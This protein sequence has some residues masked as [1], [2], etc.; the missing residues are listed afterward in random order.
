MLICYLNWYLQ[1]ELGLE[2]VSKKSVNDKETQKSILILLSQVDSALSVL[3]N[4][5]FLQL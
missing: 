5:I 2:S 1:Y 4:W 3:W